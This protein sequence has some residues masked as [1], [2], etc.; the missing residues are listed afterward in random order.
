MTTNSDVRSRHQEIAIQ[1]Y[2]YLGGESVHPRFRYV[3][4]DFPLVSIVLTVN[5]GYE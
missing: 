4:P 5:A 1:H 3:V 2:G